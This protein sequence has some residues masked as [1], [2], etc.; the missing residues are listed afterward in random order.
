MTPLLSC[1]TANLSRNPV[2]STFKIHPESHH[3]PCPCHRYPSGGLWSQPPKSSPHFHSV[4]PKVCSQ[5][6]DHKKPHKML[7]R[8]YPSSAQTTPMAK[9]IAMS[10]ETPHS[11]CPSPTSPI[12]SP[13]T[14]PLV[15]STFSH[16]ASFV[17]PHVDQA[18][19]SLG[20]TDSWLVCWAA[21]CLDIC[22]ADSLTSLKSTQKPPILTTLFKTHC[23]PSCFFSPSP[24]H[25]IGP[26]IM[27]VV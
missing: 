23:L 26:F 11:L 20:A 19:S 15:L 14:V 18:H 10:Y 9:V 1:P 6:G 8:P 21:L 24:Y 25:F 5:H 2:G 22:L 17:V 16:T 27:L 3:L 12:L 13:A 7:V 4:P